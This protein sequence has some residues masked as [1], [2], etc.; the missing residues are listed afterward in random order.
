MERCCFLC[1]LVDLRSEW[2]SVYEIVGSLIDTRL[3]FV[4]SCPMVNLGLANSV[5]ISV[6]RQQEASKYPIDRVGRR[7]AGLRHI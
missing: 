6:Y 1:C 5:V 2:G 7:T 3:P 4:A